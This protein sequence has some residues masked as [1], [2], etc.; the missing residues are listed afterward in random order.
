MEK[1]K[2]LVPDSLKR[3]VAA[4]TPDDLPRTC[5]SLLNYFSNLEPF[6][7][8]SEAQP[9]Y[10]IFSPWLFGDKKDLKEFGFLRWLKIWRI[11][12]GLSVVRIRMLLWSWSRRVITASSIQ[13]TPRLWLAIPR[14]HRAFFFFFVYVDFV[15]CQVLI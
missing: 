11:K 6:H 4:S 9:Q 5:Y 1:L 10:L 13:I 7:Q 2:S 8:V 12:E 3:I 15:V 14:F